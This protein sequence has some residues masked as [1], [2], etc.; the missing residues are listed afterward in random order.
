M[1]H[2]PLVLAQR[3]P[4]FTLVRR[5]VAE[6]VASAG[7]LEAVSVAAAAGAP[8]GE[9]TEK[10][11]GSRP[12]RPGRAA[13]GPPGRWAEDVARIAALEA[14]NERLRREL[15]SVS[16]ELSAVRKRLR[17]VTAV[18]AVPGSP[19]ALSLPQN[20]LQALVDGARRRS[21][22]QVPL[23][24]AD[25]VKAR[26]RPSGR[27]ISAS[28]AMVLEDNEDGELR[29][30]ERAC[31]FS[32]WMEHGQ[33][34]RGP[35]GALMFRK[36]FLVLADG[37]LLGFASDTHR[38]PLFGWSAM[39]M[40]VYRA[41]N[42][43]ASP[44]TV[45]VLRD[46]SHLEYLRG[47]SG[48]DFLNWLTVLELAIGAKPILPRALPSAWL[49]SAM[50]HRPVSVYWF[51]K[52]AHMMS[53]A[54]WWSR[55]TSSF[56]VGARARFRPHYLVLYKYRLFVFTNSSAISPETSIPLPGYALATETASEK[57]AKVGEAHVLRLEHPGLPTYHFALASLELLE[58]W[59]EALSKAVELGPFGQPY[60]A[61]QAAKARRNIMAARRAAPIRAR[62]AVDFLEQLVTR[63]GR[64]PTLA[65]LPVHSTVALNTRLR[66][67]EA[68]FDAHRP[69]RESELELD[70]VFALLREYHGLPPREDSSSEYEYASES[71]SGGM[72]DDSDDELS[73]GSGSTEIIALSASSSGDGLYFGSGSGSETC[74]CRSSVSDCGGDEGSSSGSAAT[75]TERVYITG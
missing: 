64:A 13:P 29:A 49:A 22:P 35:G 3:R 56:A 40:A 45:V 7:G 21:R 37:V 12:Q 57:T 51:S 47:E 67:P 71:Y 52:V 25:R 66:Q 20:R 72:S 50:L 73:S 39:S 11:G 36:V 6:S 62:R 54:G 70:D 60:A 68:F 17:K 26:G 14:E 28:A 74:V 9:A 18:G 5:S 69:R 24:L 30:R 61:R 42:R 46:N 8:V 58:E 4:R 44:Y 63:A 33:R 38:K 15:E 32:G 31:A 41:G 43:V 75:A 16:A 2:T 34:A 23:L 1:P 48:V 55:A 10:P 53:P 65:S 59:S 27:G 19:V